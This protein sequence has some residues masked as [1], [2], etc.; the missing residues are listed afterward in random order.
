MCV[1][2]VRVFVCVYVR[3]GEGEGEGE[4]VCMQLFVMCAVL[5]L[6]S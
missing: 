5:E 2:Y 6:P 3:E 1:L 4:G